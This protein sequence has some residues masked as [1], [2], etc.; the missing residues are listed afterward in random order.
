MPPSHLPV[1]KPFYGPEEEQAVIRVLRSGWVTQ[2][3]EVAALEREFAE[4]C[5]SK[6]AVAVANCTVALHLSLH[7]AGIGAGD[8]VITVSHSFIAGANAI[9]M[10][11]AIPVFVDVTLNDFDIDPSKIAA[12]I[13]PQTKAIMPVHQLGMPA[14]MEKIRV[15]AEQHKLI[16][17]EDAAC[18]IGSEIKTEAGWVK[19][20]KPFG[21]AACFSFHPRKLLATGDGGII[22][23]DDE[24]FAAH[25]RRLRQHAM[26]VNDRA[27]HQ[28]DQVMFE[29]YEEI[30]FNY[31]LTDLQAAIGRCQ[32]QRVP[33]MVAERRVLAGAYQQALARI[34]GLV[35]PEDRADTRTNWQSYCVLL[36]E[37]A[38]QRAVMQL[39]LD[40]GISTRRGVMCIHREPAYANPPESDGVR[41]PLPVS[42]AGQDRGMI[43]PMFAGMTAE[44]ARWVAARIDEA[45]AATSR[46]ARAC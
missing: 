1:A 12:A 4:Y 3:P 28:S 27:R 6:H 35:P 36:P 44:Q 8:E 19:I 2:G 22:T 40:D 34:P 39:L 14:Q 45:L 20:G 43:L 11:G 13:T 23:T 33:E 30:G 16:L 31:R 15:I 26:S 17:I 32:L 29:S 41:V 25:L 46:K 9:R 24:D 7:A 10:T 37:G 21:L 42:E 38:D 18:G 5:G